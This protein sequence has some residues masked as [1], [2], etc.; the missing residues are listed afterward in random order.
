MTCLAL[1]KS[2]LDWITKTNVKKNKSLENNRGSKVKER[3]LDIKIMI[4]NH[5]PILLFSSISL[6]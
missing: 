2:K 6:H 4:H 1:Y 3:D 5:D